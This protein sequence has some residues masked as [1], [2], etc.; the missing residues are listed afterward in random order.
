MSNQKKHRRDSSSATFEHAKKRVIEPTGGSLH[1]IIDS[2]QNLVVDDQ[3]GDLSSLTSLSSTDS[4]DCA[5]GIQKTLLVAIS[6]TLDCSDNS[7]TLRDLPPSE[8][9]SIG[10]EQQ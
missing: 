2:L 1:Q 8:F 9:V 7:L 10:S 6:L 5:K 3:D 4:E